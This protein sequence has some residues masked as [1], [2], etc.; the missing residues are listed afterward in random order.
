VVRNLD[1]GLTRRLPPGAAGVLPAA[2]LAGGA[3][4]E[5]WSA[6][7]SID[8][9]DWLPYAILAAFL[10]AAALL[11][12]GA[13]PA[14]LVATGCG[15]LFAF[16]AFQALSASWSPV[17]SLAR[18]D[19]LRTVLFGLVVAVAAFTLTTPN[20][21]LVGLWIV[22]L[23][24]GGLAVAASLDIL[25]AAHPLTRFYDGR[26]YFPITYSNAQA[27]LFLAA[28]WPGV[29]L[30]GRR[31]ASPALRAVALAAAGA[32]AAG[33]VLA[34]SKGS[35]LGLAV[36]AVVVTAASPARLRVLLAAALAAAPTAIAAAPLTAPFRRPDDPVTARHAALAVLLATAASALV[37]LVYAL[38]DRRLDLTSR[39]QTVGRA[40]GL[41]AAA[42][43]IAAV[44]VFFVAVGSPGSWVDARW[45]S[46]KH[47]APGEQT[48]AT[49]FQNLGSNRYDFWRAALKL[50]ER[51][52]VAGCGGFCFSTEYL[53]DRHSPERPQR[54]HSLFFDTA[55]EEGSI[56]IVLLAA[57]L[58]A[59]LWA[60]A[61]GARARRGPALAALAGASGF[62]AQA[63]V[64]WTWTFAPVGIAYALLLGTGVATADRGLL[65]ARR[66]RIGAVLAV[67]L[68]VVVL[69]PPWLSA[70]LTK[71]ALSSGNASSLPLAHRLDPLS[72]APLIA[73][74]TLA[75]NA[76]DE[77]AALREAVHREPRV[78]ADRYFLGVALLNLGHR[79]QA[80]AE[81]EQALALDP[82]NVSVLVA[83]RRV[84]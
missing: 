57:G 15:L 56:G 68:A 76:S 33:A 80:R 59:L 28:F 48:G 75:R 12:G 72:T 67:V 84:R 9:G 53:L 30:A 77:L 63:L 79:A 82:G 31:A 49:H 1:T 17:P 7:G 62:L 55:A 71:D 20:A 65:D 51:H 39:R 6:H 29:V 41:A 83:L 35:L 47:Y 58:G 54:S 40:A 11:A 38:A 73:E 37:G 21:R 78:V 2:L 45:H 27:A 43:A 46:F 36:A 18:D 24:F 60:A 81:L 25:L 8:A 52:P 14:R 5:A 32:G 61:R 22:A 42:A 34:Q 19:A 50:Y 64:D 4:V 16:A 74:A 69:A 10:V 13:R 66:G 44:V 3:C 23:A 70:R 26:L